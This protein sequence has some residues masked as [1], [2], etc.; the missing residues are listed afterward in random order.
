MSRRFPKRGQLTKLFRP[1]CLSDDRIPKSFLINNSVQ[2]SA[3]DHNDT[4]CAE[5]EASKLACSRKFL[6]AVIASKVL[7]IKFFSDKQDA[8]FDTFVDKLSHELLSDPGFSAT[9]YNFFCT[10]PHMIAVPAWLPSTSSASACFPPTTLLGSKALFL[11][12]PLPKPWL[13]MPRLRVQKMRRFLIH[14]LR[15]NLTLNAKSSFL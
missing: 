6:F 3:W 12:L 13:F 10:S 4:L 7:D 15:S 9:K 11:R 8:L 5:I 1:S 2:L 14:S